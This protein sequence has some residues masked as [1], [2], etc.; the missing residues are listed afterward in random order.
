MKSYG[1]VAIFDLCGAATAKVNPSSYVH[2][3]II[4]ATKIRVT[5]KLE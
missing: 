3:E 1:D 5:A 4:M 2:A